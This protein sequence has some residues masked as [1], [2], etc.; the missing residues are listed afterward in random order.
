[1]EK[2]DSELVE[3]VREQARENPQNTYRQIACSFGISEASVKRYCSGLGRSKAWRRGKYSDFDPDKLW[4]NITKEPS[5]CWVWQGCTNSSGYG[6]IH[7]SGKNV[8]VHRLAY[9]LTKSPIE[10]G[11]D[12]DHSCKN[13]RCCN[14]DH[15]EVVSHLENMSRMRES[16]A[17]GAVDTRC[18]SGEHREGIDPAVRLE[19]LATSRQES[20]LISG[21]SFQTVTGLTAGEG[22][23]SITSRGPQR[24]PLISAPPP[25]IAEPYAPCANYTPFRGLENLP[26]A[27]KPEVVK[28]TKAELGIDHWSETFFGA[29]WFNQTDDELT[30]CSIEQQ[31]DKMRK[32]GESL[33]WYRVLPDPSDS[34]AKP[35]CYSA[36]NGPEACAK[37]D[38][39]LGKAWAHGW[40]YMCPDPHHSP[41]PYHNMLL[42]N[43]ARVGPPARNERDAI[44]MIE[45]VWGHGVVLTCERSSTGPND[46]QLMGW[47]ANW[48]SMLE[49]QKRNWEAQQKEKQRKPKR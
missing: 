16:R 22:S 46:G 8:G 30:A 28:G 44:A 3:R 36:R 39:E 41:F 33:H 11:K 27:K 9:E 6:Y 5:G 20:T 42:T 25:T 23:V 2:L 45:E 31:T 43:G 17:A 48:R 37:C 12:I 15:L 10:E 49:R 40:E 7:L 29:F 47:R 24:R 21:A 38:R 18:A 4:S 34:E 13:R 19:P 32:S 1:M 26:K 14:P 35:N